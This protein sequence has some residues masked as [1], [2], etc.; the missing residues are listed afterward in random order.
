MTR[1]WIRRG[2]VRCWIARRRTLGELARQSVRRRGHAASGLGRRVPATSFPGPRV[3]LRQSGDWT[4]LPARPNRATRSSSMVVDGRFAEPRLDPG[5]RPAGEELSPGNGSSW[6]DPR[7]D[8]RQLPGRPLRTATC[9]WT[10]EAGRASKRPSATL[11][12]RNRCRKADLGRRT[13][14]DCTCAAVR[15]WRCV[16]ALRGARRRMQGPAAARGPCSS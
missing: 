3:R 4:A 1:A 15:E 6:P 10:I 7:L 13:R 11:T 5:S 9:K 8:D 16:P 14:V 2:A 12:G